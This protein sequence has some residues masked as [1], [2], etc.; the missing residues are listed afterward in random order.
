M[1]FLKNILYHKILL[2]QGFT[3]IE[4]LVVIAIIGVLATTVMLSVSSARIKARD[5]KRAGD[6]KQLI[7]ALE[8]YH[9]TNG[10]YPTG[11]ASVRSG[12]TGSLITNPAALSGGPEIFIPNYIALLPI[13]PKPDDNQSCPANGRGS[14]NYWYDSEDDGSFFTLT[15]CLGKNTAAWPAGVRTAT[16]N[17]VQ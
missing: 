17:G 13:A 3:L 11:T 9:I 2:Q 15:F 10:Y 7:S 5:A 4:L 14:N 16:P 12:G 6:V 1:I 8:Q